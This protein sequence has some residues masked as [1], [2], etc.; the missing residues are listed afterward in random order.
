MAEPTYAAIGTTLSGTSSSMN[1]D[2]PAGVVADSGV[3]VV[4]HVDGAVTVTGMPSGF[5][6]APNS[7]VQVNA[8]GSGTHRL[9]VMWKRA[10]GSD[11]DGGTYDFTLSGSTYRQVVAIRIADMVTSGDPWD[12]T[13]SAESGNSNVTATPAVSGTST[14][15]DRLLFWAATNWAGPGF[16]PPTNFIERWDTGDRVATVAT[17]SWPTAGATGSV[18]G[19]AASADKSGAW[20]GA[21]IGTTGGGTDATVN[22]SVIA[23]TASLPTSFPS[24]GMTVA[25]AA[26]AAVAAFPSATKSTGSTVSPSAITAS[27]T[28][29]AGAVSTGVTVSPAVVAA[30]ASLSAVA[31]QTGSTV[32]PAA[33]AAVAA[34]PSPAVS[35]GGNATVN[36]A[37]IAAVAAL[38]GAAL[39]TGSTVSPTA[40][41]AVAALPAVTVS[42]GGVVVYAR[43]GGQLVTTPLRGVVR[44]AGVA[45]A[46]G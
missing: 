18:T 42:T 31:V 39:S 32:S 8:G 25:P 16:T 6:N 38:P 13:N 28:M 3:V 33:V 26:I 2:V 37:V 15:A 5:A 30:V 1:V 29:P 9:Y 23:A 46:F 17:R 22:A 10:T 44:V 20:L 4:A 36:P 40:I 7:P 11:S 19:T 35:A 43:F 24:T 14:G 41:A 21:L 34:L 45:V 12:F 27:T